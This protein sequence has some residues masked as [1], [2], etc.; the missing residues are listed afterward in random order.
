MANYGLT[1]S[2]FVRKR[3]PEQ[4]KELYE[5]AK[6]MFGEDIDLSPETVM[7]MMLNIESERF[8]AL[9][10]LIESVYSAMYP[11]SAT[12][13]NLDR[14]VSFTGVT[15]LQ[16]EHSTVPVIFYGNTG[17]EIPRYTAVRNAGTQVLYYSDEDAR[18]DSNQAAYARIELNSNTINTGDVFSVVVNGVTYRFT[19]MRSSSASIIQGLANQ[20]K[21]ISYADVSNDNVI[22]E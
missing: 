13:A 11:M 14:A 17:V 12:G 7:G 15:R 9:W 5:N 2:G 6:K 8:A 18:I 3:M 16:A 4:L 21:A 19:A 10:E 20:L 22:I 1:R